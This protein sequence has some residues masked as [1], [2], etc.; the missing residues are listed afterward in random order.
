M[1]S[2]YNSRG[3]PNGLS[4][5][6]VPLAIAAGGKAV[7]EVNDTFISCGHSDVVGTTE[8]LL[9][10]ETESLSSLQLFSKFFF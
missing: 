4:D 1:V 6:H 9:M 3:G 5:M 10:N 2:E 8:L 7:P